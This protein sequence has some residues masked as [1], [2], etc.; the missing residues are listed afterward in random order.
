MIYVNFRFYRED[1]LLINKK[2]HC[3]FTSRSAFIPFEIDTKNRGYL[4]NF[5][6]AVIT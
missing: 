6:T 5:L 3:K 2:M 4:H 1:V